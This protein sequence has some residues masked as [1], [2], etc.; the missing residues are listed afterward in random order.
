MGNQN[1]SSSSQNPNNPNDL[2]TYY[3]IDENIK[4]SAYK[5]EE[6]LLSK[7][8]SEL[9]REQIY[10]EDVPVTV[11][12]FDNMYMRTL[13]LNGKELNAENSNKKVFIMLH[14]FQACNLTYY[15]M[16]KY[17]AENFIVFCPDFFGSF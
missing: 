13:I 14:G 1:D 11:K 9:T 7:F 6:E 8:C 10:F 17:L 15:R 16:L 12:N 4:A 2:K 3:D 5:L